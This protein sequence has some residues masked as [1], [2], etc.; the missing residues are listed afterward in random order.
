MPMTKKIFCIVFLL[1][2][3]VNSLAFAKGKIDERLQDFVALVYENYSLERFAEVYKVMY[4][5][6]QEIL[7][8]E[9]YTDFQEHHFKRLS[10]AISE[11]EVGEVTK[12]PRIPSALRR[13]LSSDLEH[14][15]YG[16]AL[17]Y[18][19]QFVSGLRFNQDISKSVYVAVVN[20]NLPEE[21]IYLLWDPT[22][23]QEEEQED[24]N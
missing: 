13:L 10:L 2:F 12:D 3:S 24:G 17:S 19:A 1:I 15:I 4:P 16:V 5:S 8:E 6:I 7:S 23:T 20:P 21:S 18:K 14:H 11:I 9:E 22:S